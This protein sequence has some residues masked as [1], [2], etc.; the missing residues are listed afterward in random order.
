MILRAV[1]DTYE[2]F[3]FIFSPLEDVD[4]TTLS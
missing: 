4:K 3:V 2:I 1:K